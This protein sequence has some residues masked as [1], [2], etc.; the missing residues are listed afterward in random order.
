MDWK[1]SLRRVRETNNRVAW[2]MSEYLDEM[3]TA[4]SAELIRDADPEGRLPEE[5]LYAAMMAGY[6]GISENDKAA[7]EYFLKSVKCLEAG[8]YSSDPYLKS[9]SFPDVSE[10][11]WAF[12]HYAC[13]PYEA[14][15][16][17][18]I[19][20]DSEMREIPQTGYFRERVS[21]P[22]VEQNGREW[23]AVKPSEIA[24]MRPAIDMAGGRVA[25]FGLGLGYFAFMA[26]EKPDVESVDVIE[27]SP[28]V[29]S[30]FSDY[31]LPQFP[32]HSKIRLIQ[33][34]AFRFM[35]EDMP[36][37]QYDTA[38]VDLWHDTSD[39]LDM[40]LKGR[41]MEEFLISCGCRTEFSW[42][43]EK[44]L[45]SAFRWTKFDEILDAAASRNAALRMLGDEFLHKL[46]GRAD[47]SSSEGM[48]E[49]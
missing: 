3:P 42:W 46:A 16:R 32:H 6:S 8:V 41:R 45:L 33:K 24:T 17:D 37:S 39:G 18:D 7:T 10:G 15:V 26:S 34:D 31:L 9:I 13:R 25:A 27:L 40:Y 43:V 36:G 44:S 20:V 48:F 2:A 49:E 29:I 11:D 1:E 30:M 19:S 23:M 12:T 22:A 21:Y 14:F 38:F 35:E 47:H 28:E 4:I 5:I